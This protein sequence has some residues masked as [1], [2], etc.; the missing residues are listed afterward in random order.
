MINHLR[1]WSTSSLDTMHQSYFL[2]EMCEGCRQSQ[3]GELELET[4]SIR[5]YSYLRLYFKRIAPVSYAGISELIYLELHN[6]KE[7]M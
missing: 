1:A 2:P 3:N 4:K 5:M 6:K 7:I